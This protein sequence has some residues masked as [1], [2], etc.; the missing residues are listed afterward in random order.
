MG[1]SHIDWGNVAQ[2]TGA[3]GMHDVNKCCV[4]LHVQNNF[5]VSG[6]AML[7]LHCQRLANP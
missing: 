6:L 4:Q 5:S 3:S 7:K 1:C 2:A